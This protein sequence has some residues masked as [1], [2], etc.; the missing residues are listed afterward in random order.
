M[1]TAGGTSQGRDA[2]AIGT[3][4]GVGAIIG[5]AAHGGEGAGIGAA[6]GAGAGLAG[7]LLTRGRSTVIPPET[8]LTFQLE[9]P[10]TFTTQ[11][12][13]PAFRPINQEDYDGGRNLRRRAEHFAVPPER[14]PTLYP[15]GYYPGAYYYPPPL[16]FGYYRFGGH[17]YRRW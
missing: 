11:R 17:H 12:S 10:V 5:A 8:L 16:F 2:Q 4:T 9:F 3:T 15:Y 14:R 6:V 13:S 7:V 1:Q